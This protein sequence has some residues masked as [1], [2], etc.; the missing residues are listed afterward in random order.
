V[1]DLTDPY[2]RYEGQVNLAG[3]IYFHRISDERW[4]RSDTRNFGW[5]KR[6]CGETTLRNVVLAT[7][8]WGNV[9]PETGATRE[10]QL[11]TEFVKPTLDKGAQ[12]HRH[13]DTTESAHQIIRVIL[14]NHQTQTPLQVQRE[15]VDEKREFDQTTVGEGI[16]REAEEYTKRL[17]GRIKDLDNAL[18]TAQGREKETKLQL[19]AEIAELRATLEKLAWSSR[20]MNT[21]FKRIM[22]GLRKRFSFLFTRVGFSVS[23]IVLGVL[24]LARCYFG[25]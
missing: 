10:Q 23:C 4:R 9:T 25:A 22:A 1:L 17:K 2:L 7:N 16:S 18:K 8:M 11:A 21:D 3:V 13:Y 6:I 12:L 15:L 14:N 5:L 24:Y 20:N 19:E